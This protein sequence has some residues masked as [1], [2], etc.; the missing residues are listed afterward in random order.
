[1]RITRNVPKPVI[2]NEAER[3]EESKVLALHDSPSSSFFYS[4][5]FLP[6][7]LIMENF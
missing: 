3:S 2:P 6:S 5:I 4:P 1:M 7:I